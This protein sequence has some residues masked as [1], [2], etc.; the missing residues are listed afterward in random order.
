MTVIASK[1][2]DADALSTAATVLGPEEALA[3]IE[4]IGETEAIL[5]SPGPGYEITKTSGAGK[6][7]RE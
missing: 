3:L 6:F 2:A 1:A 4:E 7:I 5:I